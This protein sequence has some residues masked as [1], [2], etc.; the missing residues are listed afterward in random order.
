MAKSKNIKKTTKGINWTKI[1]YYFKSLFNNEIAKE[2][3]VKYWAISILIFF[4]SITCTVIP[5]AVNEST[6][7][8]SSSVNN[9][10]N[11]MIVDVLY[12]Y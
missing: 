9:S 2:I 6:R 11:D 7:K 5:T 12:K 4:I 1:G 8:G 10:N 3:G